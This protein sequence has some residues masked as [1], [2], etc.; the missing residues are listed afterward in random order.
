MHPCLQKGLLWCMEELSHFAIYLFSLASFHCGEFILN[1]TFLG[2]QL[3]RGY[4]RMFLFLS[5]SLWVS[6]CACACVLA[7]VCFHG[8]ATSAGLPGCNATASESICLSIGSVQDA[9]ACCISCCDDCCWTPLCFPY[10]FTLPCL[11]LF[12]TFA[13]CGHFHL[14]KPW[15]LLDAVGPL[16]NLAS[17]ILPLYLTAFHTLCCCFSHFILLLTLLWPLTLESQVTLESMSEEEV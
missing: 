7:C 1:S 6:V 10:C 2:S 13:F 8:K 14:I 9:V 5:L 4:E 15:L 12:S 11:M 16:L 3:M 17:C